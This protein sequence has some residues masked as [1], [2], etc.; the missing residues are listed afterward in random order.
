MRKFLNE[1]SFPGSR[2]G[3]ERRVYKIW[4]VSSNETE[5]ALLLKGLCDILIAVKV[6]KERIK[7]RQSLLGELLVHKK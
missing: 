7:K 5:H 6:D 4:E 1:I 2:D 3:Q